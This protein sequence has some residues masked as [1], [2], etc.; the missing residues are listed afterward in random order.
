MRRI[1]KAAAQSA[2]A[3]FVLIGFVGFI[4]DASILHLLVSG[5]GA[6][7]IAGRVGSFFCAS[8]VTWRLNRR[9]TFAGHSTGNGSFY[10]WLRYI[11]AS[12]VGA[13]VNYSMFAVL[14]VTLP[15]VAATPTLGVAAGSLA[16]MIVNFTLYKLVVFRSRK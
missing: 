9:Y 14:V 1:T 7:P 8:F 2:P 5:A 4:V 10:E 12:G 16:G 3:R 15:L 11:W 13:A 6:R